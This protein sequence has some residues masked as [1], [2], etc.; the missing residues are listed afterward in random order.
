[1]SEA[2]KPVD[3]A[4]IITNQPDLHIV[5][6]V[7]VSSMQPEVIVEQPTNLSYADRLKDPIAMME[8]RGEN[9]EKPVSTTEVAPI[10]DQV[11]GD[12]E[13]KHLRPASSE[14]LADD[15]KAINKMLRGMPK[16]KIPEG[17]ERDWK[18]GET[19]AQYADRIKQAKQQMKALRTELKAEQKATAEREAKEAAEQAA[20]E[21][22]QQEAAEYKQRVAEHNDRIK[23]EKAEA[24]EQKVA[25]AKRE[26]QAKIGVPSAV[27][28][29]KS[30]TAETN[31]RTASEAPAVSEEA[32]KRR[33]AREKNQSEYAA[34]LRASDKQQ[35][36]G[37]KAA[38]EAAASGETRKPRTRVR[39]NIPVITPRAKESAFDYLVM[40]GGQSTAAKRNRMPAQRAAAAPQAPQSERPSVKIVGLGSAGPA[41]TPEAPKT[42]E[43]KIFVGKIENFQKAP[44]VRG[45]RVRSAFKRAKSELAGFASMVQTG[46]I[47]A[48]TREYFTDEERGGRRKTVLGVAAGALGLA[49]VVA[50]AYLQNKGHDVSHLKP[51]EASRPSRSNGFTR[52][53]PSV[54]PSRPVSPDSLPVT[55]DSLPVAPSLP[56][57]NV[58]TQAA[59]AAPNLAT[60]KTAERASQAANHISDF[61]PK[62]AAPEKV[63]GRPISF[64]KAKEMHQLFPKHT[65]LGP[66]GDLRFSHSGLV[67]IEEMVKALGS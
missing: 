33:E 57:P 19:A 14:E 43:G 31:S 3:P 37:F 26:W 5:R 60:P 40:P 6:D 47:A 2:F 18:S 22:R 17:L 38:E 34:L 10:A 54:I 58:V 44:K 66:K 25:D 55:P 65:Y 1:M 49:S 24:A 4:V 36:A 51:G 15:I 41:I 61:I 16:G 50:I 59:A 39:P 35:L 32:V 23:T 21:A 53:M 48:K 62:G 30:R 46:E 42:P 29:V 12:S 64:A 27:A 56:S 67:P 13:P 7:E 63:F 9:S 45:S 20:R 8:S 52:Q 11:S 28:E